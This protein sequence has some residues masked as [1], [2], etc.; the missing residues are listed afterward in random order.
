M[1][2][3]KQKDFNPQ[4]AQPS[5]FLPYRISR[6]HQKLNTQ[7]T[8]TLGESV[9]LTL[10]QWRMLAFIGGAE[11]V[12]ASEPVR[13]TA[14]DKC[15]GSRNVKALIAEGLV[16]SCEHAN[17]NRVHI[18]SLTSEGK[19]VFDTALPKMR[20]RQEKLQHNLSAEDVTNLRRMPAILERAAEKVET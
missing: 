7:A 2:D 9:G 14:M 12:T 10:N 16:A 3:L 5:H 18:L 15:L 6:L 11:T 20:R 4:L 17:D 1:S 8:Q 13:Y 19:K